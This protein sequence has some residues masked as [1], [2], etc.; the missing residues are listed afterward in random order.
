MATRSVRFEFKCGNPVKRVVGF[1]DIPASLVREDSQELIAKDPK[2]K[3]ELYTVLSSI[4][5]PYEA[6]LLEKSNPKCPLCSKRCTTTSVAP[7]PWLHETLH[8]QAIFVVL[9][10]CGDA[11]CEEGIDKVIQ[12]QNSQLEDVLREWGAAHPETEGGKGA[13]AKKCRVCAKVEEAQFC[14]NCKVIA[15]CGKEHQKQ[16]WNVHKNVCAQ[17]LAQAEARRKS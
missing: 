11:K 15:Y 6:T 3:Q 4:A 17:L 10:H 12:E 7:Y 9:G 2:Y 13:A 8:P 16:D 1:H 5:T 14:A